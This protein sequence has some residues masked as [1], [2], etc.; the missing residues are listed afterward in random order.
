M[1]HSAILAIVHTCDTIQSTC[2]YVQGKIVNGGGPVL[3][4]CLLLLADTTR[5]QRLQSRQGGNV[6]RDC[7]CMFSRMIFPKIHRTRKGKR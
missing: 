7:L 5:L 3:P 4:V 6:W 1:A 2:L